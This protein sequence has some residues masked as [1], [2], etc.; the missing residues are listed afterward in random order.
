[1]A[2][3]IFATLLA[4]SLLATE[5]QTVFAKSTLELEAFDT[6][7]GY[8]TVVEI[9]DALEYEDIEILVTKPNGSEIILETKSDEDGNAKAEIDGYH[10][11]TAGT[12]EICARYTNLDEDYGQTDSFRVYEDSVSLNKSTLEADSVTKEATGY[13]PV[14]LTIAL[15]DKY[16]NPIKGHTMEVISSRNEDYITPYDS[17]TTDLQGK[18]TFYA[19]SNEVGVS[20]FTAYDTTSN[21]VLDTRAKIAFFDSSTTLDEIGGDNYYASVLLASSSGTVDHLEIEDLDT[22]AEVNDLLNFTVTAYDTSDEIV[23]N[24]TGTVRFS[25][26]DDNADLPD[27]YT[28]EADDQGTHTFSLNLRFTTSGTQTLIVTDIDNPDIEGE[29]EME[30]TSGGNG[31]SSTNDN[32]TIDS[33]E[34]TLDTPQ[35]GTYS[36]NAIEFK[37]DAPYGYT[38]GVYEGENIVDTI[39][40][41]SDNTFS[42]EIDLDNGNHSLYFI[43]KDSN[44]NEIMETDPIS[45]TIDTEAPALDYIE[46]SPE[47]DLEIEDTFEITIFTEPSLSQVGII[48]DD[49]I[50][51]L[52]ESIEQAGAYT[53]MAVAPDTE[54]AYN[55]DILLVDNLANEMQYS[56]QAVI[57]VLAKEVEPPAESAP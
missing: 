40:T 44:N 13:D 39:E 50:Y 19:Y 7:A 56:K 46:I 10:L 33:D 24:Y 3:K 31:S 55:I 48:L 15:K 22:A 54:G 6:V 34:F 36:S 21:I 37:G 18:V 17:N 23:E 27:D 25:S 38:I 14:E 41:S 2:K 16:G 8:T 45:I 30:I 47:G 51:E 26:S 28:F 57:N 20:I 12:Y 49:K 53:G 43:L 9:E 52:T 4:I 29:F 11:K 35:E 32:S 42:K 1:M 5:I